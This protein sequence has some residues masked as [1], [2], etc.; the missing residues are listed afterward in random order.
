MTVT[1]QPGPVNG[2]VDIL[3]SK[4]HLHRLLIC[5]ALAQGESTLA[6]PALGEDV[7]ATIDCLRALGASIT[8]TREYIRISPIHR[9]RLPEKARLFCRE[10]GST[11]R[12]LLPVAAALGVEAD[13]RLEGRLPERPLFPLDRELTSHGCH[14]E[15]PEPHFLRLSGRL[16]PGAYHLPGNISS[17]YIS[18]LLFALSLLAGESSLAITEPI[19]SAD[20]I[21]MTVKAL[22]AFDA[23]PE[24]TET[25]Y[26]I[27]GGAKLQSPGTLSV[28]GDW[29]NAAFWLLFGA[30]PGGDVTCGNLNRDSLQGDRAILPLLEALGAKVTWEEDGLRVQAGQRRPLT[31]DAAPIPDLIPALAALLSLGEG[32]TTI[33]NAGRLRL[34]ES[35]RLTATAQTLNALGARV[36]EDGDGLRIEG[37]FSLRGGRVSSFGDHRIAMMAALCSAAATGPVTIQDAQAV[38]KS[39]PG[40]WKELNRLGKPVKEEG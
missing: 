40:F 4:S 10:S 35:D 24:K 9:D 26:R 30:M 27:P 12:F 38:K 2:R 39:Y 25:G 31:I 34:K 20:Y 21:A 29:S 5:A 11:L 7:G 15:R 36:K 3:P 8:V 18:G 32:V 22:E 16:Q 1:L 33:Q 23:A 37:A 28:E 17:Q 6:C 19:E 13:F 14:L